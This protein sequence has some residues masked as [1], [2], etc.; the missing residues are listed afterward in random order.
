MNRLLICAAFLASI[1]AHA[2]SQSDAAEKAPKL[3]VVVVI[4]QMRRSE[5][6]TLGPHLAGGFRRLLRGPKTTRVSPVDSV[7]APCRLL[8]QVNPFGG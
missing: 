6:D 8:R 7:W 2:A 5:F 1:S 4:D 3:V